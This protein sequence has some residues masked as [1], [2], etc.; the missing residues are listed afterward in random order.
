MPRPLFPERSPSMSFLLSA[1]LALQAPQAAPQVAPR[2]WEHESSD[3][4]VDPR[5][6]FGALPNGLR[7]AW[8][9]NS[10]PKHRVYLR[11]HVNAGSLG[12]EDSERGMAHFLEHMAFN[13]SKQFPPDELIK[14]LQKKGLSFGAD[15]NASTDF[16]QTIYQ[17]D[18]PTSDEAMVAD[19]LTVMRDVGDGLLLADKEVNSEKGVI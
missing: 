11:M 10:E 7:Y 1:L 13:G 14:W 4:K 18:L 17:L 6:H 12:E 2:K 5:I 8:M 9:D 15:T 19:G 3:L 16:S